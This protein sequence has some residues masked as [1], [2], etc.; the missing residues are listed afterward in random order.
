MRQ[1]RGPKDHTRAEVV[2]AALMS[3]L[4]ESFSKS[5]ED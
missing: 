3:H 4:L 2:V 1:K 5:L